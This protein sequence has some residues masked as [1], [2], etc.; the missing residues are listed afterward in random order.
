MG[1]GSEPGDERIEEGRVSDFYQDDTGSEASDRE[2]DEMECSFTDGSPVELDDEGL[3]KYE[4]P[5][6]R[7]NQ[8]LPY[9]G[10]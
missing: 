7:Q 1:C 5:G 8:S 2:C 4:T 9:G 6:S 3:I 10:A